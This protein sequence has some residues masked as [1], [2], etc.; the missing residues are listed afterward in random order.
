M[1]INVDTVNV[2]VDVTERGHLT[3]NGHF[4]QSTSVD[5]KTSLYCTSCGQSESLDGD[6]SGLYKWEAILY[7]CSKFDDCDGDGKDM[8]E[9]VMNVMNRYL[10]QPADQAT[11]AALE[12]DIRDV[13]GEDIPLTIHAP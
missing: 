4:L 11:M 8:E 13:V 3:Y 10:G 2:E 1:T 12:A 9:K 7:L 6:A 5:G